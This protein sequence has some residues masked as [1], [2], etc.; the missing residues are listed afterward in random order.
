MVKR[1]PALAEIH[2]IPDEEIVWAMKNRIRLNTG[3]C[4]F[5]LPPRDGYL[6]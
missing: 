1:D 6:S 4:P 3:E 2:F 5:M